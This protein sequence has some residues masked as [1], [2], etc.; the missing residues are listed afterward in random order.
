MGE[1]IRW[2]QRFANYKRALSQLRNAVE[3]ME[4]RELSI[5]EKQGVIQ[6]F[7][8]T[9]ELAWKTLKDFLEHR[10]SIGIYGSRDATKKAFALG[11]IEDGE[12]WM[13]MIKSRNLTSYTYDERTADEI[14]DLIKDSYFHQNYNRA[15]M[16]AFI[17]F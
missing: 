10:G 1:N 2:I 5:L 15:W 17:Y 13:E 4:E 6:S 9:H 3:L 7:E 8:Y 14:I 11:L 12:I 16:E